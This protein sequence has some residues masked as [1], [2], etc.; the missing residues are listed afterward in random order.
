MGKP[1]PQTADTS[2]SGAYG[3]RYKIHRVAKSNP[4]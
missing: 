2:C 3:P 1:N 4:R